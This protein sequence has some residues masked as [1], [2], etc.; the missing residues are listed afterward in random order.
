MKLYTQAKSIVEDVI[1]I[2]VSTFLMAIGIILV[3]FPIWGVLWILV[4]FFSFI[5]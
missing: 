2:S 4:K 5:F 3:T 1:V